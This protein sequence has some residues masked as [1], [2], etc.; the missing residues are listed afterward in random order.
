[1]SVK[2]GEKALLDALYRLVELSSGSIHIDGVDI[3]KI[4]PPCTGDHTARPVSGTLNG[5]RLAHIWSFVDYE[6]DHK[7]Q[8]TIARELQDYA[9][10]VAVNS[11]VFFLA[12]LIKCVCTL[13]APERL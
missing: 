1:M 10:Q 4:G 12:M 3:S 13:Q 11:H 8:E 9:G 6:T 2:G 7:F 5:K